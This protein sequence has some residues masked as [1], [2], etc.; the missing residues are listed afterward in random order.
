MQKIAELL[1]DA[2]KR[3]SDLGARA[4]LLFQGLAKPRNLVQ[5]YILE[6]LKAENGVS[7]TFDGETM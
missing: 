5:M 1:Q 7:N 3:A 6:K 4:E 2:Q